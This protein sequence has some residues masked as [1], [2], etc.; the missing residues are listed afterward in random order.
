M[1]IKIYALGHKYSENRGIGAQKCK[2]I[3]VQLDKGL[4]Y[5]ADQ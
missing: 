1:K 5:A 2:V 3:K 4:T